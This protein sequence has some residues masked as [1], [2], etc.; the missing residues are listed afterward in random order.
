MS[1]QSSFMRLVKW[2]KGSRWWMSRVYGKARKEKRRKRDDR[3]AC[4]RR[5]KSAVWSFPVNSTEPF[6]LSARVNY[7]RSREPGS[8][9][10]IKNERVCVNWIPAGA[11]RWGYLLGSEMLLSRNDFYGNG[12]GRFF[13][14]SVGPPP[15][16]FSLSY[17]EGLSPP[18]LLYW[19]S[20]RFLRV[21]PFTV[22]RDRFGSR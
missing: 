22:H 18:P 11:N 9:I 10:L 19:A 4:V 17:R 15:L 12:S 14:F 20:P 6:R 8:P 3:C 1:G 7:R 21:L 5:G 16:S 2:F 13:S